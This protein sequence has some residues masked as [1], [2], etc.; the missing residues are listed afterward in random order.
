MTPWPIPPSS[1]ESYPAVPFQST[2][3]CLFFKSVFER[4][5][6]LL[7]LWHRWQISEYGACSDLK[8]CWM[9]LV[10]GSSKDVCDTLQ[11]RWKCNVSKNSNNCPFCALI[12]QNPLRPPSVGLIDSLSS[13]QLLQRSSEPSSVTLKM[14]ALRSTGQT[15][16]R[17]MP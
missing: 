6:Q 7:G 13:V 3:W 5:H 4:R 17:Y 14:E 11:F 12:G 15:Q 9:P 16:V 10:T 1:S 8:N 2:S